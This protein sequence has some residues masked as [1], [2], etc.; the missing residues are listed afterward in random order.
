MIYQS[1]DSG[2][3]NEG[4]SM[5]PVPPSIPNCEQ[6]IFLRKEKDGQCYSLLF[7]P[8]TEEFSA[9]VR[10]MCQNNQPVL[11]QRFVRGFPS[12]NMM[13]D[14]LYQ[15]PNTVIATVEFFK[16]SNSKYAFSVQT[17]GTVRWFKGKFQ[18]PHA[19]A[20]IPVMLAVQKA[21]ATKLSGKEIGWEVRVRKYPYP[22]TVCKVAIGSTSLGIRCVNTLHFYAGH[23]IR[24][25]F[26]PIILYFQHAADNDTSN[27]RDRGA[28]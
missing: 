14:Y 19:Y 17:N 5:L 18:E 13:D 21:L 28:T 15:H 4:A 3:G 6:N 22:Q 7:A 9:V 16:E 24:C 25:N 20:Q 27:T 26:R 23:G 12:G 1:I 10:D 11:D 2:N 8:D